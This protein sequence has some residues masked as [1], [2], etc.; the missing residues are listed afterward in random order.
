MIFHRAYEYLLRI[1]CAKLPVHA[2][3]L[4]FSNLVLHGF[5]L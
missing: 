4:V 1:L 5:Y 2:A 3:C